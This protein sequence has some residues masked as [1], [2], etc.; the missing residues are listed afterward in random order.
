MNTT[1]VAN[2]VDDADLR[3]LIVKVRHD[4][5]L[6]Q[7]SLANLLGV[8]LRTVQNW[9]TGKVLPHP[10]HRRALSKLLGL[11][12]GQPEASEGGTHAGE[13]AGASAVSP[14]QT[15]KPDGSPSNL[16]PMETQPFA[17]GKSLRQFTSE[18]CLAHLEAFLAKC[19]ASHPTRL[20]WTVEEMRRRFP[21]DG[22]CFG[23]AVDATR[24]PRGRDQ[25]AG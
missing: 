15:E 4:R 9:E 19:C 13:T 5:R 11:V 17:D 1:D 7:K 23:A 16:E 25:T 18:T 6:T 3:E 12:E 10:N 22:S 14:S 24:S 2:K 20:A 21:L 8:A